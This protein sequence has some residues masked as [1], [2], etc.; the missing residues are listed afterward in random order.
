VPSLVATAI[1]F[2]LLLG[3]QV[4]V[5]RVIRPAGHYQALAA[6]YVVA[7]GLTIAVFGLVASAPAAAWIVPAGLRQWAGFVL[8]YTAVTLA[9]MVTYSAVQ[10]DS[11]SMAVLL[12]IERAAPEG[13]RRDGLAAALDDR[14]VIVP[15]LEDLVTGEL[16]AVTA[17]RY[18]ITPRGAMLARLYVSYRRLLKMEK[19]G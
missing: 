9:Y 1:A 3:G 4:L 2:A 17:G 7:L 14:I 13:L 15:R 12:H 5:W 19:G 11:P 16:A 8:L 6:L 10:A 18:V